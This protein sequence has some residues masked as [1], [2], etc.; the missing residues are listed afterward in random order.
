MGFF[1]PKNECQYKESCPF[2]D[3]CSYCKDH[4]YSD[5]NLYQNLSSRQVC[6]YRKG[7]NFYSCMYMY[8]LE[9][10][11]I[12]NDFKSGVRKMSELSDDDNQYDDAEDYDNDDMDEID[13]DDVDDDNDSDDDA[14][15]DNDDDI[16]DSDNDKEDDDADNEKSKKSFPIGLIILLACFSILAILFLFMNDDEKPEEKSPVE[17]MVLEIQD[18]IAKT[19]EEVEE[20]QEDYLEEATSVEEDEQDED[21][22]EEFLSEET[23][24]NLQEEF[25]TPDVPVSYPGGID[26]AMNFIKDNILYPA[27]EYNQG[28]EGCVYVKCIVEP[29]GTT[30]NHVV[31]DAPTDAMKEEAIRVIKKIKWIP[32]SKE[33]TPVRCRLEIPVEFKLE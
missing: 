10:C 29:D 1:G 6:P 31:D 2:E 11:D 23:L 18:E 26:E 3:S 22:V 12:Y 17:N 9:E 5:C 16:D 14:E 27:R 7:C 30:S 13:N 25:V 33:G 21:I 28:I 8:N 20:M 4:N 15:E 24:Q 32:A 19:L